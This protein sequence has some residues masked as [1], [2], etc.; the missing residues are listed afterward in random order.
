MHGRLHAWLTCGEFALQAVPQLLHPLGEATA[1]IAHAVHL[2]H[3]GSSVADPSTHQVAHIGRCMKAA[4]TADKVG[5]H[6][7]GLPAAKFCT[8]GS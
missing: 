5:A 4:K 7:L 6:F 8:S 1:S 2:R 3:Q